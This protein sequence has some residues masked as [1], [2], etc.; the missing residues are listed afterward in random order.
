[1]VLSD[2][3][4]M[5]MKYQKFRLYLYLV[6]LFVVSLVC[7]NYDCDTDVHAVEKIMVEISEYEASYQWAKL[8]GTLSSSRLVKEVGFSY[9]F[10]GD[11]LYENKFVHFE[12]VSNPFT[13]FFSVDLSGDKE[14]IAYAYCVNT[15][16]QTIYSDPVRIRRTVLPDC[17]TVVDQVQDT[18]VHIILTINPVDNLLSEVNYVLAQSLHHK[19]KVT[20]GTNI[21]DITTY[22]FDITGLTPGAEYTF[23]SSYVLP[24]GTIINCESITWNTLETYQISPTPVLTPA[25][26]ATPALTPTPAPSPIPATTT[27][28]I[29]TPTIASTSSTAAASNTGVY[30]DETTGQATLESATSQATP[31][32]NETTSN[33]TMQTTAVVSGTPSPAFVQTTTGTMN[34]GNL[35]GSGGTGTI[36]LIILGVIAL[37]VVI[38]VLLIIVKGKRKGNRGIS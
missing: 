5:I 28:L 8:T 4:V 17:R 7:F 3:Q 38:V 13:A 19:Q 37:I 33:I 34:P 15:L 25:A 32:G 10:A 18:S 22:S 1:M 29:P 36:L 12:S 20:L 21:A 9:H 35:G 14:Y 2:Y 6:G 24:D 26:T 31:T 16:G 27:T 30:T 11:L 23:K